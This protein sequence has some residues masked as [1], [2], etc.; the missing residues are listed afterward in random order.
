MLRWDTGHWVGVNF[1]LK[2]S[3]CRCLCEWGVRTPTQ[4]SR[5]LVSTCRVTCRVDQPALKQRPAPGQL[6]NSLDPIEHT[7]GSPST[8]HCELNPHLRRSLLEK[9]H[10]FCSAAWKCPCC[11][12]FQHSKTGKQNKAKGK[13][14]DTSS[15][16]S[17]GRMWCQTP[18]NYLAAAPFRKAPTAPQFWLSERTSAL[19]QSHWLQ[20]SHSD[21]NKTRKKK[22]KEGNN[23]I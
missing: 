15:A 19:R 7:T 16:H 1:H 13:N 6:S 11:P 9:Y 12:A 22:S 5:D 21:P 8:I 10:S 17:T 4:V 23:Y 3:N 18:L 14:T 20:Q 2:A